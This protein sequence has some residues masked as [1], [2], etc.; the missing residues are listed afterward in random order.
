MLLAA[1]AALSASGAFARTGLAASLL[2]IPDTP[3]GKF[4]VNVPEFAARDFSIADFGAK[5]GVKSTEAFARAMAACEANGGGRVVVPKGKWLTGAVHFRSNCNLHLAEGATLEFTDD[6]DD[7]PEVFTTWE[8]IECYNYSPLIYAFGVTN[9]AITGKGL[10]APRMDFWRTWFDRPPEHMKATEHLYYWCSTNAPVSSRRLLALDRAHMRPHLMQFNRCGNVLLDGFKIRDSPFWMIHLYHS[11]DCVVR[12]LDTYARGHNNDGVDI[13]MTKNVLVENCRF[14]QGDDGIVLKAG[15]NA[16]AWRIGRCTEN[17]VVRDCDLVNSHSLL[18]IGSELSGGVRNVWMTRCKVVD[19]FSMLRIKTG[20]R[21]GG[22]VENVWIDHCRGERMIR[23]F[24]IFTAYC[25]LRDCLDVKLDGVALAPEGAIP[26]SAKAK[27]RLFFAGDSTLDDNG[28]SLGGAPKA[29]YASWGT[30]LRKYLADGC[31]VRNYAVSG[32]STKSFIKS[33][34]WSK[35]LKDAKPGDY[36]VIQFGHND[37]KRS[38]EFYLNERWADPKGAFRN[39]VRAMV[40][41]ARWKGVA[42]ILL[43]PICRGTFD[44]DGKRLVDTTHAS[45]GVCLGSYRD[46]MK[47][48]SAELDCDYV[49]MNGLTRELLERVGRDEAMKFFVI[50]TGLRRGKDGEPSKDVTHPVQAGAEA[51]ARLFLDDVMRRGLPLAEMFVQ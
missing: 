25:A 7:Y 9:V 38:S 35:L 12:N 19:T 37:Q 31:E 6:P 42:P 16:D 13:D 14:D 45:D 1:V 41:E 40:K 3:F 48:L 51:F 23:V 43:S 32:A 34:Q 33:G 28:L 17:V 20:P 22:F 29:P 49:D 2:T 10:I 8:G 4:E 24:N 26:V 27:P 21:R 44:K 11:E 39:N 46:A 18:G 5:E 15:R 50:S 47:E 30:T 36:V